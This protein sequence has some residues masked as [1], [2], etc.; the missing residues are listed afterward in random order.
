VS[1]IYALILRF[2]FRCASNGR[3]IVYCEVKGIQ[4][5]RSRPSICR[6]IDYDGVRLCLRTAAT[7]GPIVHPP[8]NVWA[9]R[10]IVMM[11]LAGD[12][13]WLVNQSSLAVLPAE[14]SGASRRNGLR[15][16]NFAY[17]YLKY[18]KGFL[19]AVKSYDMGPP[20]LLPIRRK[21]CNGFLSSLKIHSLG[22]VWTCNPAFVDAKD[23]HRLLYSRNSLKMCIPASVW[24][25]WGATKTVI[26]YFQI[27]STSGNHYHVT[28]RHYVGKLA[29]NVHSA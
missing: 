3:T 23:Q 15:A 2:F 17:R 5:K 1:K 26:R 4:K 14:T 9:W 24:A 11:M 13:S 19:P 16:E 18:L 28:P 8:G 20:A 10:A 29:G 12:I 7:N 27:W 21:V 25:V 22:R 6:L